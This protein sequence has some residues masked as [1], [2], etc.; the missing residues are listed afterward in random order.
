MFAHK[1]LKKSISRIYFTAIF[2]NQT[3]IDVHW[4]YINHFCRQ[5]V[6]DDDDDDGGKI[7]SARGVS[8]RECVRAW[9]LTSFYFIFWRRKKSQEAS[10]QWEVEK[11]HT[12]G[13][14]LFRENYFY[15]SG[16]ETMRDDNWYT[17][18]LFAVFVFL[19]DI[20]F[21]NEKH[22]MISCCFYSWKFI[23][24]SWKAFRVKKIIYGW[25]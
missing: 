20:A 8:I 13:N 22:E 17:L 14:N 18:Q 4:N 15:C 19:F 11:T 21:I 6:S 7:Y 5:K 10:E 3:V 9:R 2:R 16:K 1:Y 24:N 25:F 12:S 23:S